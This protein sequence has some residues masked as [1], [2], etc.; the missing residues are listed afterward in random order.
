MHD[1]QIKTY[2]LSDNTLE[3]MATRFRIAIFTVATLCIPSAPALATI[4]YNK[5]IAHVGTQG[6]NG[7]VIFSVVPTAGCNFGGIYL[8]LTTDGG[9]ASYSLLLTAYAS[10]RLISRIDYTKGPDGTCTVD[11]VEM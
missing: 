8:N 2:P 11:L 4:E 7:Y 10:N 5:T 9:K 6:N 1:R 3:R